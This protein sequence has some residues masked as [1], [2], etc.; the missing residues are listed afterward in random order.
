MLAILNNNVLSI[1]GSIFHFSLD[2]RAVL[3]LDNM[4]GSYMDIFQSIM[5]GK[6]FF[7]NALKILTCTCKE[8][9]WTIDE[10]IDNLT[11]TQLSFGVPPLVTNLVISYFGAKE[12]ENN[13]NG[14]SKN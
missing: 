7:T 5:E 11:G 12:K 1:N 6:N 4:Y 3:K 14:S 8:R 9:E 10:L 13:E 2:N